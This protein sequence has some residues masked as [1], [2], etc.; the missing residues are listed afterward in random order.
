MAKAATPST[1]T[2]KHIAAALAEA[3]EMAKKQSEMILGDR[4]RLAGS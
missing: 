3:H 2:L 4:V 1:I